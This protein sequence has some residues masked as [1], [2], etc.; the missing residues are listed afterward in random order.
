MGI[1]GTL[2]WHIFG[3]LISRFCG[4]L[5]GRICGQLVGRFVGQPVGLFL[6]CVFQ[7]LF[8]PVRIGV[9][10]IWTASFHT[11]VDKSEAVL[12][13][14]F[15]HLFEIWDSLCKLY[16]SSN[17][18]QK[19]VLQDRL[20]SIK[21]LD[22]ESVPSFLGRFTEISDELATVGE[23]VDPGFM[24]R[25]TLNNF[26]KPWGPLVLGIVAR[27]VMPTLERLWDDFI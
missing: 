22:S 8:T 21:M 14:L 12:D 23:I 7:P 4:Q 5:V 13:N 26:S 15:S 18:N 17:K 27:E 25:T 1:F 6:T 24:V 20:R 3:Q 9:R 19:M 11:C 10:L 2:C 16:Q